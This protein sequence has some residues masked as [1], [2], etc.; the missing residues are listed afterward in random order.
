MPFYGTSPKVHL[1]LKKMT[2]LL[3]IL[4]FLTI[5]FCCRNNQK[6]QDKN[7]VVSFNQKVDTTE[8]KG[9]HGTWV[10]HNKTGFTLIEIK[11]TSNVLYY[12]FLDRQVDLGKPTSDRF[13]YYK[14]KAT[15]GYWNSPSNPYKTDVDIWIATDKFR[16]DYKL[17]GD[18]LIEFDKMGDQGTFIKVQTDEEKA[19]KDFNAANLKGKI[20]YVTKV[21]LSEFFV[22]DNV[23]WEYSFTSTP[24]SASNNKTFSDV[25]AIGDSIIKPPFADTLT[26]YKKDGKQYFKFA[27]V[28]R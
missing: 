9:L 18:T 23:D 5:A 17:K 7:K 27:F 16:F 10:R 3:F 13:W 2:K 1:T 11:D 19:F 24:S 4:P 20:T 12:Q 15:M 6:S 28:R 25:A 14:S 22:L 21:D 26:L 8:Y